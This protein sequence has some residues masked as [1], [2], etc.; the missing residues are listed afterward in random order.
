MSYAALSV[1]V[2][3]YEDTFPS[4]SDHAKKK[5]APEFSKLKEAWQKCHQLSDQND[6]AEAA[7]KE[8]AH[9]Q[10]FY[11]HRCVT[12]SI[13]IVGTL[14]SA[15]IW[16]PFCA[17][18]VAIPGAFGV[19]GFSMLGGYSLLNPAQK[20]L[21]TF[22]LRR[23]KHLQ[24]VLKIEKCVKAL[25]KMGELFAAWEIAKEDS[26]EE[27]LNLL[28]KNFKKVQKA[29]KDMTTKSINPIEPLLLMDNLCQGSRTDQKLIKAWKEFVTGPGLKVWEEDELQPIEL[30]QV[31]ASSSTYSK[32]FK[33]RSAHSEN[34]IERKVV[35]LREYVNKEFVNGQVS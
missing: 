28:F 17:S 29:E 7:Y 18:Y 20:D 19:S 34:Q 2:S 22:E 16:I 33:I 9:Y 30:E 26:S 12:S 32:F 13:G 27:N 6:R 31:K 4:I 24:A 1:S 3:N 11:E 14:A 21:D 15:G 35:L 23:D 8:E 25:N 10:L 5:F